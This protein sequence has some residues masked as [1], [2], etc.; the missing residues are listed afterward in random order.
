MLAQSRG[1]SV[2]AIIDRHKQ[3]Y[4]APDS[5]AFFSAAPP[6]YVSELLSPDT[7]RRYGYFDAKKVGF[8]MNKARRGGQ[9]AAKDNMALV[10]I[11]SAQLCHHYFIERCSIPASEAYKPLAC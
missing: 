7:L 1:Q 4:R 3:P 6:S 9:I 8:L 5:P 2:P 10:G 11:L